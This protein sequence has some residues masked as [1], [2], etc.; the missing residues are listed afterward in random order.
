MCGTV[1]IAVRKEDDLKL[2]LIT[3][4]VQMYPYKGEVRFK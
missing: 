4:T 1:F 2:L 3:E